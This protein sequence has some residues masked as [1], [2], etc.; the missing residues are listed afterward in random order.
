[1]K[2]YFLLSR[3]HGFFGWGSSIFLQR[4]LHRK[5]LL[6]WQ[7]LITDPSKASP[8]ACPMCFYYIH[9]LTFSIYMSNLYALG[10]EIGRSALC[11]SCRKGEVKAGRWGQILRRQIYIGFSFCFKCNFWFV[12]LLRLS[13]KLAVL[14][15]CIFFLI[16]SFY[17][18]N[19]TIV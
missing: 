12:I 6:S 1:M 2:L 16:W 17:R 14:F 13:L 7:S 4:T 18:T 15:L 19:K 5:A 9:F 11:K 8:T 10:L 3:G